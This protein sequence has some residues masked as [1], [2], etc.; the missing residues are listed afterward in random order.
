MWTHT[1][2]FVDPMFQFW[3]L[4]YYVSIVPDLEYMKNLYLSP[5]KILTAV[6]V[7]CLP[8]KGSGGDDDS[9][10][11]SSSLLSKEPVSIGRV[12]LSTHTR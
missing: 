4:I 5:L 7:I 11:S 10:I 9:K 1:E 8:I 3:Y 2:E 12:R 6:V